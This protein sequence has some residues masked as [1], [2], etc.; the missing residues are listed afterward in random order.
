VPE[1]QIR[2]RPHLKNFLSKDA[3]VT[4]S[5]LDDDD[6]DNDDD[7][8]DVNDSVRLQNPDNPERIQEF[9][10]THPSADENKVSVQP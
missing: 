5:S 4:S 1:F 3:C 6:D 7:D 9:S 8:D 2:R 10:A